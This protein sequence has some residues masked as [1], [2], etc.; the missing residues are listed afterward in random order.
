MPTKEEIIKIFNRIPTIKSIILEE[1]INRVT[2]SYIMVS[3][4]IFSGTTFYAHI[5]NCSVIRDRGIDIISDYTDMR[6]SYVREL[7]PPTRYVKNLLDRPKILKRIDNFP[8]LI[9]DVIKTRMFKDP[10][11]VPSLSIELFISKSSRF[12]IFPDSDKNDKEIFL[13]MDD[14]IERY[15]ELCL[16]SIS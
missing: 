3:T 9:I 10:K 6:D 14:A 7:K 8:S 11:F 15:L 12:L 16:L 2:G 4:N 13:K 5:G 1:T